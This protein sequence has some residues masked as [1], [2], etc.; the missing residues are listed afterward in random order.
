MPL[1]ILKNI[2]DYSLV[3]IKTLYEKL[4]FAKAKRSI[5][6]PKKVSGAVDV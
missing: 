4:N 6:T 1:Q 2:R 5:V 3:R